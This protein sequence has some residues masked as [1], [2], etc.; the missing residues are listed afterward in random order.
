MSL[1][2]PRLRSLAPTLCGVATL[3]LLSAF[4][5]VAGQA[6]TQPP[7]AS[8]S[9]PVASVVAPTVA[10]SSSPA[11]TI[12]PAASGLRARGARGSAAPA[13]P[14]ATIPRDALPFVPKDFTAV[15]PKLPTLVIA[16][17]STAQTGDNAHRGWAALLNDYF[18]STKINLV[19]PSIGGR[20]FRT[21][22]HEGRWD[23]L[24]AGLKPGDIVMI[25]FGHNDGGNVH[26]A[27]G[28]PDLPGMGDETESVTLANGTTEVVHTLGWYL[29]KFIA[30]VRAKGATPVVM[31]ATPYNHWLNGV[32]LHQPGDLSA[33]QKQIADD[34]KVLYL[35]HTDIIGDRYDQLG[36]EVVQPLFGDGILHTTT[37]GAIVNAEAF[38]AGIKALQIKTLTDA[39]N[40]KGQV[41][42]VYKPV[43]AKPALDWVPTIVPASAAASAAAK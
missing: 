35:N 32:F 2:R 1:L 39:L 14:V 27:N 6:Q 16:G 3:G 28:R 15:N 8:A 24:V 21:F 37:L 38:I 31:A 30:D 7:A 26:N 36:Q 18:D 12:P 13:A 17:D 25:Q 33:V 34:E 19:N 20:S 42:A 41:I 10:A 4:T 29:K 9:A 23:Q 40:D 11:S 43:P 5:I 22:Y